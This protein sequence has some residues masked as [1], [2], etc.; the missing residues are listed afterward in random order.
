[1]LF[2]YSFWPFLSSFIKLLLL[3]LSAFKNWVIF[4]LLICRRS[5]Y[6]LD[7]I[8]YTKSVF[9]QSGLPFYFLMLP[10]G[11]LKF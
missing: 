5:F 3:N 11:E 6:I 1:M 2:S 4:T 10:F 8:K 7:S 9:S